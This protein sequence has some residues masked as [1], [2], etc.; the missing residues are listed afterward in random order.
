MLMKG[1]RIYLSPAMLEFAMQVGEQRYESARKRN[2]VDCKVSS[3]SNTFIDVNAACGEVAMLVLLAHK[4]L[5]CR[6]TFYKCLNMLRDMSEKSA[7][8]GTDTGDIVLD[9][10]FVIDV[11]TTDYDK[12][13]SRLIV[14]K[15]KLKNMID[16]YALVT[17]DYTLSTRFTFR[18]GISAEKVKLYDAQGDS[19]WIEQTDLFDADLPIVEDFVSQ[20]E[21]YAKSTWGFYTTADI[22]IG[23]DTFGGKL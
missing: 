6:N 19:L 23:D 15:K 21:L 5:I 17:G 11:K 14:K 9:S 3:S 10:G 12:E 13:W 4:Q 18:G 8:L 20:A 22:E 16:G 1:E 2:T 7:A